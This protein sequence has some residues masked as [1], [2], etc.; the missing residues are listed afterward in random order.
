MTP[1]NVHSNYSM[2]RG[3]FTLDELL[4]E[5]IANNLSS[6][7]LTDT[8]GMYGLIQFAKKAN[9]KN[10][11]PV[12]GTYIDDP[13][14]NEVNTILLAKNNEGYSNICKIVTSRKLRE[15]FSL[16]EL[17]KN[18]FPNLFI[19]T[20]SLELLK[21]LE[22]YENIY[23][24]LISTKKQKRNTRKLFEFAKEKN[25][26]YAASN[27]V[28]FLKK[29]DFKIH[30]ILT[31][32]NL[33]KVY[34]DL[35]EDE[36]VE[37]E[38]YFKPVAEVKKVWSKFPEAINNV[39]KIVDDCK[40]DLKFNQYKYPS[41]NNNSSN[42]AD[43]ILREITAKALYKIYK[44]PNQKI[45]DRLNYELSVISELN[46][47]NYFLIVDDIV[48]EAK[49]RGMM[50]I[51]RGS[52]ANSLVAYCLGLTQVDPIKYNLYFERFL[53]KGRSNPPDVDI[54]FSWKERDE[55]V[56]Y[57]FD[58][59]GYE[60]VAMISTHVT[61]RARSAF[62]EVAKAFGF[63]NEEISKYSKFIPWTNAQNLSNLS[64]MF[65]ESRKLNFKVEPWKS[66]VLL[67]ERLANFPRHLS[68][69]PSGIVITPKPINNYVALEYAKNKGLGLIITQPDMYSIED[70]GLIKIDLL[71]Q[72][73]LGVLRDTMEM[74]NRND[75]IDL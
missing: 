68:I 32:I 41:Y 3:A 66:I 54:D 52:A 42:E 73:S 4:D 11:K 74:I 59:Y 63:S 49:R 43:S 70:L 21:N 46:F 65:P 10:I 14:N 64:K 33:N 57:V 40:V 48:R 47:S 56:K 36:L 17:L 39:G 61:F 8:N 44:N 69:H 22:N 75:K 15:D 29:E 25:I 35:T 62:R 31:A 12:L 28:Y 27:P 45:F 51:G 30:K 38:F 55:I 20:S 6:I 58:K 37:E 9:E 67:A 2:L 16:I 13:K 7:S 60:N 72:R 71:S 34:D 5:A 50:L 1:L 26:K 23:A 53:N 19:I 24:E 18:N